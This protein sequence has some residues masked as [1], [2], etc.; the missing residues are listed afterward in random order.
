MRRWSATRRTWPAG[1]RKVPSP[2]PGRRSLPRQ[3]GRERRAGVIQLTPAPKAGALLKY[4]GEPGRERR[5]TA[6]DEEYAKKYVDNHIAEF[7]VVADDP[8][9]AN[10]L[11]AKESDYTYA[12]VTYTDG[13]NAVI[14]LADIPLVYQPIWFPAGCPIGSGVWGIGPKAAGRKRDPTPPQHPST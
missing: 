5:L 9:A 12:V 1:A 10:M 3:S 4:D 2:V 13:R 11:E 14:A 8:A 6:G 7:N